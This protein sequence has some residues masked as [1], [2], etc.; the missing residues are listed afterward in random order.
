MGYLYFISCSLVYSL[1]LILVYFKKEHINSNETRVF[2]TMLVLNF[3]GLVCELCCALLG[4]FYDPSSILCKITTKVYMIYL[5]TFLLYMTLYIYVVCYASNNNNNNNLNEEHYQFLKKISIIIYLVCISVMLFLPLNTA[6]GYATGKAV[7]FVYISSAFCILVWLIPVIKNVKKINFKKFIPLF[8]FIVFVS[9][10]SII[11][12]INP[13]ITLITSMESLVMFIMYF[14]IENP[15]VKMIEQLNIAKSQA[16]RAN[17][18]K[19][20]FLSNMSHE[21]R[22][23]LNAIVGFSQALQEENLPPQAQDEV[24][25]IVMASETL[26]D[27]VNGIL[28]ISKIEANK[29][30][31]VSTEYSLQAVLDEL[32]SLSKAR[33][34]E[35]PIEFR[36]VFDPSIPPYLYGDKVRVKQV[37]LN[38]LTNAIK[39][40]KQGFIEFKVSSIQK[41][42]VC[43]LIISVE[44]S[45]IGIK[46]ESINK[47][48]TKFERLDIEKNNTIEGTGLGL[49]IT[50]KLLELMGGQIV[51]QSVYGKGSKF[52]IALDQKIVTNP[53]TVVETKTV[54][55][56]SK[57][58]L[59]GKKILV[60]DDNMINLKVASRLLKDYNCLV[61]TA[62]SGFDCIDKISNGAS[63]DLILMDDMMPK[64]SGVETFHK[65]KEN[66]NF[67]I[68]TV[69][70]TA[71]AISGMKEKYLQEGFQD[72]LAK[73][74]EKTELYR[75]LVKFLQQK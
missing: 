39:Y 5:L 15:D 58:D 25:D 7:D 56:T 52:T 41:D 10:V 2:S 24:K 21:I 42:G 46:S 47:L 68:P 66:E 4:N 45:G 28:D 20:D 75:V 9:I 14:T 30:E 26:L 43:R 35:K 67:H 65:L 13:H 40:T 36:C 72:Y 49:A 44:D 23:P 57:L 32:V 31:I 50:K 6:S 3:F 11:Q 55:A 19:S 1:I 48:F 59:T 74:I 51:V 34:G 16:E 64:M 33:L 71:N 38:I 73:P 18:A 69:A 61:D 17:Q 70:L 54:V 29:L 63:Y 27:I 12:K 62:N 53:T 37:I 8:A 60:V 22:T